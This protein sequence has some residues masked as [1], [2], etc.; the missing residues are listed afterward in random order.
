MR[1][2][3]KEKRENF[4]LYIYIKNNVLVILSVR[5]KTEQNQDTFLLVFHR[6]AKVFVILF[7]FFVSDLCE[8]QKHF[9]FQL[10]M[11]LFQIQGYCAVLIQRT[12]E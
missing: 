6:F 12:E 4:F 9:P 1:E 8:Q 7:L 3:G 11:E 10:S 5:C 2:K